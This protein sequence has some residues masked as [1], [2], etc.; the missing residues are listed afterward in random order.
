MQSADSDPPLSER[1]WLFP[2]VVSVIILGASLYS[3]MNTDQNPLQRCRSINQDQAR[4]ACYDE[5]AN[6]TPPAKGGLAPDLRHS[7]SRTGS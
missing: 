6:P 4:L 5:A 2:L 7:Q 1:D 3:S